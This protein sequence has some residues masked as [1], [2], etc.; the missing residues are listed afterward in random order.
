MAEITFRYAA[1]LLD[2]NGTFMFGQ[3]RFGPEFDYFETYRDLGGGLLDRAAVRAA[4][5]GCWE[6][7]EAVADDPARFDSFPGVGETL[8]AL[9]ATKGLPGGELERLEAVFARHEVGTIPAAYG[10]L[11]QD[12]AR[13]HRLGLVSNIWSEKAPYLAGLER[14]GLVN[15]LDPLL[16]SSDGRS[17]KPSRRLFDA[18]V[19][20]LD[21]P[22]SQIVFIG[23]SLFRDVGGAARA[24]L[25]TVW[26]DGAGS[27]TG[28]RGPR[29]DYIISDLLD[30]APA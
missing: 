19:D 11:L 9:A 24:G 14:A 23:D 25:A 12:L 2:L 7:M 3:D 18:A 20:A 6:S 17:I 22:P 21:L 15:L 29:P 27:G 1:V 26:I 8:A 28:D 4:I 13:T 10:Q 16:F 30:L 5:D